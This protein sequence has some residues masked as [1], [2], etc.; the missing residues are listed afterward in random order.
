M[1]ED[2]IKKI[3]TEKLKKKDRSLNELAA[4]LNCSISSIKWHLLKL[5]I[6]YQRVNG[7]V[8]VS[9]EGVAECDKNPFHVGCQTVAQ[10]VYK[11]K[12]EKLNQTKEGDKP[13][14]PTRANKDSKNN[15]F[16]IHETRLNQKKTD[17]KDFERNEAKKSNLE[18]GLNRTKKHMK[19][20]LSPGG[21]TVDENAIPIEAW[22]YIDNLKEEDIKTLKL[23]N[24]GES[25]AFIARIMEMTQAA[26]S[27]RISKLLRLKIVEKIDFNKNA[28]CGN[29][30]VNDQVLKVVNDRLNDRLNRTSPRGENRVEWGWFRLHGYVRRFKLLTGYPQKSTGKGK[31]S[32][33]LVDVLIQFENK[34]RE[35][36]GFT[37][38]GK[39]RNWKFLEFN[40][41]GFRFEIRTK[42]I[43]VSASQRNGYKYIPFKEFN[44]EGLKDK[45]RHR[46]DRKTEELVNEIEAL[47]SVRID[48]EPD[49][50]KP[51][52][53]EFELAFM[54]SE[55]VIRKT[56]EEHGKIEVEGFGKID[57]SKGPE[58]EFEGTGDEAAENGQSFKD[59]LLV[60]QDINQG[61]LPSKLHQLIFDSLN[62]EYDKELDSKIDSKIDSKGLP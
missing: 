19:H 3:L 51:W 13:D 28:I 23:L 47:T 39:K 26:V 12:G 30:K 36:E 61:K 9:L 40:R 20:R 16:P 8:I 38:I 53:R 33:K 4:S 34:L 49:P 1:R 14:K 31:K 52:E 42:S 27:K 6:S 15:N 17:L 10:G 35:V 58:F 2:E 46:I 11:E 43:A 54:D 56:Y 45:L 50:I 57:C 5:P 24:A 32:T 25:Q 7:Q 44:R 59:T 55:G 60:A 22:I 37:K 21:N 41:D 62:K 48:F 29:V 18:P